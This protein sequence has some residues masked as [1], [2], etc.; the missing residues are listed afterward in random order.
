[1]DILPAIDLRDGKVVR[2]QRG[3]YDLQTTYSDNP[4]QQ[5]QQFVDAGTKWIHIVDLDAA[6]SGELTNTKVIADICKML[7][8]TGV[9]V[10]C[11]G[12]IRDDKRIALLLEAGVSRTVIG[13]AALKNWDWFEQLLGSNN[14]CNKNIALGLDARNGFVAA[15]GWTQQLDITAVELAARVNGSDLGAIVYTDIARDG[16]LEGVN[17]EAT[18]ELVKTTTVPIVASGGV[19]SI[20]DIT[21]CQEISCD[22]VI[23][24]KALYENKVNLADAL[25]AIYD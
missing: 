23:V 14:I 6:R 7:S 19:G 20:D 16:M 21:R 3:D 25:K 5:A 12:G 24:G 17:I 4:L 18:G 8:G 22:G 10:Q 13:S 11:G 15:E 1:M 2:L 9:Q